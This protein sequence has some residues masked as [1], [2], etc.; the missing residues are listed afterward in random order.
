[1]APMGAQ[2]RPA[3]TRHQIVTAEQWQQFREEHARR[4]HRY[5]PDPVLPVQAW[6][7]ATMEPGEG[8]RA[9]TLPHRGTC[10]SA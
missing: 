9:P 8:S 5:E 2:P 3:Q 7:G 6:S 1:M 10:R 4:A